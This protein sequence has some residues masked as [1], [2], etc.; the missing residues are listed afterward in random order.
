MNALLVVSCM[1]AVVISAVA[2]LL[3]RAWLRDRAETKKW[4]MDPVRPLARGG[5]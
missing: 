4:L 5:R 2:F 1:G 3:C